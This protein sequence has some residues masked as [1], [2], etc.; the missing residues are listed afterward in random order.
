MVDVDA[1]YGIPLSSTN[2]NDKV[3]AVDS[4]PNVHMISLGLGY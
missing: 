1:G 2:P 4:I 3:C